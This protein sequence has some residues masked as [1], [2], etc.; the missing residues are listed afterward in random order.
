MTMEERPPGDPDWDKKLQD[1]NQVKGRYGELLAAFAFPPHWVVRPIP[2]DY[3][4][5]LELEVFY[6]VSA[7]AKN[8]VRRYQTRGEHLYLQVKTTDNLETLELPRG[9]SSDLPVA[10]FQMSTTDLKLVDRMGASVPVVLL[11]VDRSKNEIYYVCLTDYVSHY[12]DGE[13]TKWREQK[14]VKIYVPRRN[15]L[16][17]SGKE[18]E[19]EEHWNYFSRLARRSK[20]FSAFNLIHHYKEELRNA[21]PQSGF[22]GPEPSEKYFEAA[23]AFIGRFSSYVEEIRRQDVWPVPEDRDWKI[24]HTATSDLDDI[25]QW[26]QDMDHRLAT[27]SQTDE[28]LR[29][30]LAELFD[31]KADWELR[32]LGTIDLLGRDYQALGRMERLPRTD[33]FLDFAT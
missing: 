12:L 19:L 23:I 10:T 4:L 1:E 6:E 20:L 9:D 28:G 5:D 14:S 13:K 22:D 33:P 26:C 18:N 27:R 11:L 29:T 24:L 15:Q 25:Y 7:R 21:F 2:D 16:T 8:G 31:R 3:G 17:T 30:E 32:R